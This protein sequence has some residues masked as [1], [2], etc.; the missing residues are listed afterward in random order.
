MD[1]E[2]HRLLIKQVYSVKYNPKNA[3][4]A[5]SV[6]MKVYKEKSRIIK[7]DGTVIKIMNDDSVEVETLR[8][9]KK[10]SKN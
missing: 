4:N 9:L 5:A 3:E 1:N 2:P 8:T 10:F 6:D 7:H